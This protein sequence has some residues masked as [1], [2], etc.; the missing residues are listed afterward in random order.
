VGGRKLAAGSAL[1]GPSGQVLA[2]ASA[3]WITMPRA[4]PA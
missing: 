2:A 4:V 1:L 3:V